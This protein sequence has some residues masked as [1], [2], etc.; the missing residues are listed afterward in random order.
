MKIVAGMGNIDDY[1]PFMEAGA[2]EVFCGYV[3]Y[4]YM[5][6]YG[7]ALPLNRREVLYYNVQIGSKSEL[8]ILSAMKKGK[9]TSVTIAFNSLYYI[10]S[11]YEQIADIINE[12]IECGFDS[13]IVADLGLLLY[14]RRQNIKCNLHLSGE[15]GEL[16][17]NVIEALSDYN[18]KRF[19]FHRKISINEMKTLIDA[20]PEYE[21]E[22]FILNEKCHFTGAYCNSLHCDE[23]THICKLPYKLQKYDGMKVYE[24][25]LHNDDYNEY[26][27]G[28]TG[29][30]LCNLGNLKKAGVTHLKLVSRGNYSEDTLEDIKSLKRA[31]E[32]FNE[33][34]DN[35]ADVMKKELFDKG[36][37]SKNCYW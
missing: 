23:L 29:C 4:K 35:S 3:P 31:I 17:H 18:I 21:Y 32:I 22:A 12:C 5:E 28:V 24:K 9:K 1:I 16:N 33:Y 36:R 37:C 11:Q 20:K 15:Y 10:P 27:T 8:E 7:L 30:G 26:V 2:D 14:L 19:I 6:K 34:G 25:D 13:F